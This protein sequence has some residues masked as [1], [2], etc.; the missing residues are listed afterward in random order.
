MYNFPLLE[1]FSS[2]SLGEFYRF[3]YFFSSL[4]SF[5]ALAY[6]VSFFSLFYPILSGDPP[7]AA[8]L[9]SL[10]GLSFL[11]DLYFYGYA[12]SLGSIC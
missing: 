1:S 5:L 3:I 6:L 12:P 11:R 4:E 2:C 9:G 8:A 7:V 10:Y